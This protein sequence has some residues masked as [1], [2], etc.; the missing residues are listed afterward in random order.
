MVVTHRI[1]KHFRSPKRGL[2][3]AVDEVSIEVQPGRILGLL[4]VNGAGKTTLLRMLATVIR[5][6]S[7]A[8]EVAGYDIAT[9]PEQVRA[10]VGFL[11]ASTAL[12]GRLS[13]REMLQYFGG[14]YGLAGSELADRLEEVGARLRLTDFDDQL[15]DRLSSGQKQRV[16]IARAILHDPPVLFFDEPTIGLDVVTAQTILEFIEDARDKGK[17]VVFST[18]IMSEAERLCDD[19]Q[20]IHEGRI[21]GAGSPADLMAQTSA[22][23]LEKAFLA[24]VGYG[25]AQ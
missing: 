8:A 1:S 16:S 3:K 9:Q 14:L 11:S 13:A 5:P 7:G 22:R 10:S 18:H 12:Y 25:G 15:C 6:T 19:I 4:G 2:I 23:T 20:V 21:R 17:T 24:L